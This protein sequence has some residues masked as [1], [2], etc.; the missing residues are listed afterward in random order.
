MRTLIV[1][2]ASLVLTANLASAAPVCIRGGDVLYTERP[3]D[4]TIVFHMADK[5]VY[6]NDL[7]VRCPGLKVSVDGFS[8][9][10]TDPST[11]EL[12]D[13]MVM[14]HLNDVGHASCNIGKFTRLK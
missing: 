12:C 3:N 9:A 10:P 14:I 13:G 5:T 4:R 7:P 2:A 8:F 11:D 1:L 6:R